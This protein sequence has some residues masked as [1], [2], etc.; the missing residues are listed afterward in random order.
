MT[1]PL[2]PM[3]PVEPGS[4]ADRI[5]R[6]HRAMEAMRMHGPY[7]HGLVV[8]AAVG[9]WRAVW[10]S[11]RRAQGEIQSDAHDPADAILACAADI[12]AASTKGTNT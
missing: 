1:T 4:E 8:Y 2:D 3:L 10:D 7:P 12:E 6:D 9:G 5:L 11:D